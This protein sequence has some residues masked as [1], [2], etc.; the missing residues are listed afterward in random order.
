MKHVMILGGGISGLSLAF[1][2]KGKAFVT[3]VEKQPHLG[4]WMVSNLSEGFFLERGPRIFQKNKSD[5]LLQLFQELSLKKEIIASSPKAKRRHLWRRGRLQEM[6]PF[7]KEFFSLLSS[8]LHEVNTPVK[9]EDETVYE[10]ISRRFSK[11]VA[12][13]IFDPLTLGIFGGDIRKLS[14]KACFPTLKAYE[15]KHGSV[16]KGFLKG[17]KKKSGKGLFSLQ[18]GMGSLIETLSQKAL[19]DIHA[20]E[21][22][23]AIEKIGDRF[24]ITTNLHQYSPDIVVSALDATTIGRLF[25]NINPQ[26]GKALASI[27]YQGIDLLQLGYHQKVLTTCGFGYLVPTSEKE[28]VMG[29]IFDSEVFP[30]QNREENQTRLTV[31]CRQTL[32]DEDALKRHVLDAL[33]RHLGI[34]FYPN[35]ISV[36][37]LHNAIPQYHLGHLEKIEGL[38]ENFRSIPNFYFVGNYLHGVSVDDCIRTSYEVS[39]E[40]AKKL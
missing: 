40:I 28:T 12:E 13:E 34:C 21:E 16:V 1:F 26:M 33:K 29:V 23:Q 5:A 31:M 7:T 39:Q 27:P 24:F 32:L 4:G 20:C 37:R 2:L 10:F 17:R 11:K 8:V 25:M 38:R 6:G 18:Q 9:T 14:I 35:M 3:L 30:T 22:V 15:Q 36:H 19:C